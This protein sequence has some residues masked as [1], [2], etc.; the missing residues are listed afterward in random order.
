MGTMTQS[1]VGFEDTPEAVGLGGWGAGATLSPGH[2]VAALRSTRC[3]WYPFSL[4]SGR[5]WGGAD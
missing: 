3:L 4:Q 5:K 1:R 2:G